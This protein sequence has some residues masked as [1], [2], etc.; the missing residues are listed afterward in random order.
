MSAPVTRNAVVAR[1]GTPD[2]IEGS[3]NNPEE[4]EEQGI[5]YNEKW[6]YSHLQDDPAGAA[7]RIVYWHRYDFVATLVRAARDAPW[8]ADTQLIESL[9]A[10]SGRLATV[11][12]HH[13]ALAG[14][15]NYRP[16][17][18]VRDSG[19]L[20]GYIEGQEE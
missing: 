16:V 6:I 15:R 11:Q 20:G 19:D 5:R 1:L 14:N 4:M 8:T 18:R 7:E 12:D 10:D 9:R 17:S 3:L 13:A 2:H